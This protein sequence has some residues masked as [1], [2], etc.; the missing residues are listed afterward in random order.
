MLFATD[1]FWKWPN[2][3][4]IITF[5]GLIIGIGSVWLS[6]KWAKQDIQRRLDEATDRAS[7]AARK[8]VRRIAQNILYSEIS[9]ALRTLELAREAC[10]GRQWDR[11]Q[12]LCPLGREQLTR[13]LSQ[14]APE[15]SL[16]Q[17]IQPIVASLQDCVANLRS[18]PAK[19]TGKLPDRVATVL[20]NSIAVLHGV[21]AEL[22]L[23]RIE[24]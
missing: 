5:I 4:D 12:F 16:R 10:T 19:G 2:V 22:R 6:W 1:T 21:D 13:L 18:Q 20:D 7:D 8:E 24:E 15:H 9:A 23:I 3:F 11:A 14:L 17:T